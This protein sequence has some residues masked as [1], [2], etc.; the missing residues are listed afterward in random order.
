MPRSKYFYLQTRQVGEVLYKAQNGSQQFP[1]QNAKQFKEQFSAKNV[2]YSPQNPTAKPKISTGVRLPL[3][4]ALAN[5]GSNMHTEGYIRMNLG[6]I[7]TCRQI[8]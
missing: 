4:L 1:R 8:H 2:S 7:I 3:Y 5:A 6:K